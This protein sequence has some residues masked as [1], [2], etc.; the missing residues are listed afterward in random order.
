MSV[1]LN[2]TGVVYQ[3][4]NRFNLSQYILY[5]LTIQSKRIEILA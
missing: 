4:G 3:L 5:Y 1:T 2:I